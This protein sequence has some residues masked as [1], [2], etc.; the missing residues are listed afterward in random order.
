MATFGTAAAPRAQGAPETAEPLRHYVASI[1]RGALTLLEAHGG[2]QA[3]EVTTRFDMA[4]AFE[5]LE[6][7]KSTLRLES[8]TLS[9][10]TLDQVFLNIAYRQALERERAEEEAQ[11]GGGPAS[12]K[13]KMPAALVHA[14]A[15]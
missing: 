5:A 2:F 11:G 6:R 13:P 10:T 4:S 12:P 3:F 1:F 9:Q 15:L 7:A 14:D 8:Y